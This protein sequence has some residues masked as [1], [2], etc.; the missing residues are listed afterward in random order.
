MD[1]CDR[2]LR[3]WVEERMVPGA[4]LDVRRGGEV[5][6]SGGYGGAAE[7]TI[8]DVA[9]LTKVIVTLPSVLLLAQA[10]ELSL[11]DP[12]SKYVPAFRHDEVTIEQC[13]RHT[14][15]MPGAIPGFRE[16][17][18]TRDI[19]QEL[20]AQELK[21]KPGER[22]A[23]SDLGMILMGWVVS[24]V[25]GMSLDL[26]A[27][28]SIFRPLGMKDSRFNPPPEWKERIAPTE[29]SGDAYLQGEVHDETCY[30]LGGVSGNAGLFS[31]ADDIVRY[32][33]AWLN[34]EAN[35]W[36]DRAWIEASL[37][38]P[39]EARG[40]GWQVQ[41]GHND[42][43]ACGPTWPIGSFGH[44]GFTGTSL[45]IDPT[46]EL[47]VVLLTNAV[48]YGRDNPIRQLRPLLHEAIMNSASRHR[49]A[50]E[51]NYG[52]KRTQY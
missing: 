43:L 44:T 49:A 17:H 23:Y 12:V 46:S 7:S 5:L 48:H 31:T 28:E 40:L 52:S 2:L 11:G 21:S 10:S 18:A 45:W 35:A 34:P 6:F 16:R 19:R 51:T 36:L 22:V 4:V 27:E 13:L 42:A 9:S 24:A 47:T 41:D 32:A 30:R 37:A 25:S 20:L 3:S 8:F 39:V 15:G 26:F 38:D 29:W 14:S 33:Q 1:K 50:N